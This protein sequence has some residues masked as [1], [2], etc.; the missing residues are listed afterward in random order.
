MNITNGILLKIISTLLFALMSAAIRWIGQSVPLGEVVFFRSAFA[1]IP[2]VLVYAVQ[3][4]LWSAFRTKR[5]LGHVGRGLV[6]VLGMFLNFAALARLPLADATVIS[7][8]TPLVTVV[9]AALV[10]HE[11]VRIYRWTAV[12]VGFLGVIVMLLPYLDLSHLWQREA[13]QQTLGAVMGLVGAICVAGAVVQTRRLTDTETTSAIVLYFSLICAV[14][15][16]LTIPEWSMPDG[17]QLAALISIGV[18][19]GVSHIFLTE[20]Y[21][22]APASVVAPFDYMSIIWAFVLGY[23]LFGE[24]PTRLVFVGALIVTGA[25][26]FVV[27]R[28]WQ[29][30]IERAKV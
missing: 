13:P 14:G 29:L 16:L 20:S 26:L 3:G 8:A 19:G 17:W 12:A 4:R 2:I 21:R 30:G 22:L 28:E 25:G 23:A 15:G 6:G 9:L 1:I 11:Q 5:P 24:M 27:W 7:F 18:L 10:L